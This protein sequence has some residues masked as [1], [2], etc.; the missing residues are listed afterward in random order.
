LKRAKDLKSEVAMSER[1]KNLAPTR[2]PSVWERPERPLTWSMEDSE[3]WMVTICGGTLALLGLRQRT[4]GGTILAA[5]AGTA[6]V[7]A[8]LG[9]HDL[10][11]VRHL[12]TQFNGSTSP[13]DEVDYASTDSFPASDAP[14][15]TPTTAGV[16]TP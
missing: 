12:A 5:L 10:D 3:R 2:G 15:W 1:S 7:R 13:R 9:Y 11:S 8:L 4:V 6:A 16:R 14:G